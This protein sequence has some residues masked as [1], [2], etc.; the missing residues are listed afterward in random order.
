M[1]LDPP[2]P[3][4]STEKKLTDDQLES[5]HRL[6]FRGAV[7]S[8]IILVF[9]LIFEAGLLYRF[10]QGKTWQETWSF[11][12][13]DIILALAICGEIVGDLMAHRFQSI[14]DQ[15]SKDQL[16]A[17]INRASQAQLELARFRTPR[18]DILRGH[19]AS[20]TAKLLPFSGAKFDTGLPQGDGEP[21]DFNWDLHS[22]LLAAG[23]IHVDWISAGFHL[24]QGP[25]FPVSG[26]VGA[27]NVEIHLHPASRSLLLPA[28]TALIE[29]LNEIGIAATDAGFNAHSQNTDAIHI[30]IGP[31]R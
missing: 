29:A 13:A 5:G 26:S 18:R 12:A 25:D 28:A 21:A 9:T 31:K 16:S 10:S 22:P 6:W 4:H 8:A 14:M 19:E 24:T 30:L 27:V 2:A 3:A 20:L 15:R 11:I 1:V 23:W 17:A 7:W